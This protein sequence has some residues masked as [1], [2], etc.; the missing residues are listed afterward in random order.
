MPE[1]QWKMVHASV[2]G[3]FHKKTGVP[4]Q[5]ASSCRV[6]KLSDGSEVLLAVASDG[7]GSATHSLSAARN[8][9]LRTLLVNL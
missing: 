2:E 8:L 9:L 4:C 5:D 3:S 1:P 6:I 7:A